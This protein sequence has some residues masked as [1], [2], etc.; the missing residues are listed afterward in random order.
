M[1]HLLPYL[2]IIENVLLPSGVGKN[3]YGRTEVKKLLKRLN[4]LERSYHKPSE[5]ST[6]EK[7]RTAIA[8][9]LLNQPKIVLAD[10]PAGNLDVDNT[11]TV[12][13]HLI[14][15]QGLLRDGVVISSVQLYLNKHSERTK[16]CIFFH[17][18]RKV[19]N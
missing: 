9:A 1:F 12:L 19:K 14:L 7:Q 15:Q 5:L 13:G 17:C 10:D 11:A 2:N 18:C 3:R 8:R 16:R 4:L 6:G